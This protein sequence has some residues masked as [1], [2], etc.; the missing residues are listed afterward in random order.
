MPRLPIPGQD[1]GQ[2]GA[3]LNDFLLQEHNLDGSL[4]NSGS[5]GAY[6]PLSNP[7]FSGS[8][9]VPAPVQPTDAVTKAYVD[10]VVNSS[11][12]P[13]GGSAS[14][15]L[16]K[17]SATDYDTQWVTPPT[18]PV[19]SVNSQ[20]GIVL[21]TTNDIQDTATNRYTNDTDIT[22]LA[23]T[24]GTNTGD[25]DLSGYT[26]TS[27]LADVAT[28]GDYADLTNTPSIPAAQVNSDWGAGSGVAEILNKPTLFSGDYNDLDNQPV[29][30]TA[31]A[32]ST[33][34][35]ATASQGTLAASAVQP[36]DLA[37]VATTGAYSDLSGPPSIPDSAGDIG[38]VANVKDATGLWHG[39]ETEY[40]AIGSPD[41]NVV[42]I[43]VADP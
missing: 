28:S 3:I 41:P 34:D 24:S 18:A 15:V 19:A 12:L 42:Y 9:T 11:S 40:A 2:W 30:G 17:V 31:A 27:S 35:F 20:T 14:Q 6:A 13:V 26:L 1:R 39:T 37:T 8:V 7:T 32:A 4:K 43:V 33:G 29:L 5:L 16:A 22:R 10:A 38:A 23:N 25:Q 36:S 21:L